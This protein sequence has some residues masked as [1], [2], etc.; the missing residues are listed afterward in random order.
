MYYCGCNPIF[1]HEALDHKSFRMITAQMILNDSCKQCDIVKIF[2]VSRCSVKRSVALYI[3]KG[4]GGFYAP[5]GLS[6]WRNGFD[7]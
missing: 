6:F 3:E 1:A 7:C 5:Q 4:P 2:G